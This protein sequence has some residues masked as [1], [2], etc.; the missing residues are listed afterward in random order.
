[1]IFSV[2]ERARPRAQQ[3]ETFSSTGAIPGNRGLAHAAAPGDGRAPALIQS[4][5]REEKTCIEPEGLSALSTTRTS[6]V[7]SNA[8]PRFPFP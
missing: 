4:R 8:T 7:E 6:A 3:R 5:D 1:M 2:T